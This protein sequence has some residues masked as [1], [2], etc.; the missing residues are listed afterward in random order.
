MGLHASSYE[1]WKSLLTAELSEKRS[2]KF[3]SISASSLSVGP[4]RT[5]YNSQFQGDTLV[6]HLVDGEFFLLGDDPILV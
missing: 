6:N 1:I 2:S 3:S 5:M 4:K